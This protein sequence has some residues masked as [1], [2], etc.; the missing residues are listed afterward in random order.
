MNDKEYKTADEI[1]TEFYPEA[2]DEGEFQAK[3]DTVITMM[4]AYLNQ[5]K[6]KA[7]E[8]EQLRRMFKRRTGLVPIFGNGRHNIEYVKWI[9]DNCLSQANEVNRAEESCN[10]YIE[11]LKISSVSLDPTRDMNRRKGFMAGYKACL[12]RSNDVKNNNE[13]INRFTS[14]CTKLVNGVLA[15]K[16]SEHVFYRV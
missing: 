9:Q 13:L 7:V 5:F 11:H 15:I 8:V 3:K 6:P 14:E 4:E 16:S 1:F 10:E 2:F 12:S